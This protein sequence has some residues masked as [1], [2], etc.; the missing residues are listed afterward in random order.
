M[1]ALLTDPHALYV[2]CDGA[3]DYDRVS[4]GGVGFEIVFPDSAHCRLTITKT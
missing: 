3:M 4:S 2:Y 1:N